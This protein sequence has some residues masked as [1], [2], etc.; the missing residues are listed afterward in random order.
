MTNSSCCLLCTG[1]AS[2]Y[3]VAPS[4]SPYPQKSI[5]EFHPQGAYNKE[6]RWRRGRDIMLSHA[7]ALV[8]VRARC[9]E[10][11]RSSQ[12]QC[13]GV[14]S[15]SKLRYRAS[16]IPSNNIMYSI[17]RC[18][19]QSGTTARSAGLDRKIQEK[20]LQRSNES[21]KTKT[22]REKRQKKTKKRII[23]IHI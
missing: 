3:S 13:V 4:P 5:T 1:K 11:A 8:R 23:V 9:V 21:I 22:K 20:H 19:C 14:F 7:Y 15:T 12:Q 6:S 18:G 2:I 10:G 16:T 17:I